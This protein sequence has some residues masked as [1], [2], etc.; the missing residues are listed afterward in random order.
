MSIVI[1]ADDLT[2][3]ND[4]A[5]AFAR[6]GL[7]TATALGAMHAARLRAVGCEVV[8]VSTES[9]GLS[10]FEAAKAV[11]RAIAACRLRPGDI[12]YKKID[13]ALRGP[14]AAEL[15]ALMQISSWFRRVL[16]APAFPAMGRTTVAG[17]Q[18][19]DGQPVHLTEMADDPLSPVRISHI[20]ALLERGWV[21]GVVHLPLAVVDRGI[22]A[23]QQWLAALPSSA[24][25]IVADA[26][27][28]A[29]LDVLA[30][31]AHED[32]T[33]LLCGTAGL[34]AALARIFG[35]GRPGKAASDRDGLFV[36]SRGYDPA[37]PL[38]PPRRG[39]LLVIGSKSARSKVQ[40]EILRSKAPWVRRVAL[41]LD[42]LARASDELERATQRLVATSAE[43]LRQNGAVALCV[44]GEGIDLDPRAITACLGAVVKGMDELAPPDTM[45]LT[46]GETAASV[47]KAL[48]AAALK[49]DGEYSPGVC[50]GRII[51]GKAE[52]TK[53]VTKAGSFGHDSFL[54]ELVEDWRRGHGSS[55]A[56]RDS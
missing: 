54:V 47:L 38:S 15:A 3:A 49:I 7:A 10:D 45:F 9:R 1:V 42:W 5:V 34:A 41:K 20:P 25:A 23:V 33:L 36:V 46:G 43:S 29:H 19:I 18:R 30:R 56:A 53:V 17:E 48:K 16:V 28:D 8:A 37:V 11:T 31:A 27:T 2:G 4:T 39:L 51:G 6:H 26:E 22:A 21:G 12:V 50:I 35:V 32:P 40:L 13:S 55:C 14:I 44:S 52:G 24:R